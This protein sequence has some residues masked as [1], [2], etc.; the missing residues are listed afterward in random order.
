VNDKLKFVLISVAIMAAAVLLFGSETF[1]IAIFSRVLTVAIAAMGFNLLLG[2]TGQISI[3]HGAFMAIGAYTTAVLSTKLGLPFVVSII[4][5]ILFSALLGIVIGL[6]ALRLKGFYLAI[7]TLAFGVV[8]EQLIASIDFLGGHDGI[9][10]IPAFFGSDLA[11]F[12]VVGAVYVALALAMYRILESP[13]GLRYRMVRDSEVASRAYGVGLSRVKLS[14]FILSAVYGGIA[15]G[16][17]AH[18]VGFIVPPNF[19]LVL[20]LNILAIVIIGGLASVHGGLIGSIVIVGLPFLFSRGFGPYLSVI[21]GALLIIFVLFFPRGLAHGVFLGYTKYL[22][23]PFIALKNRILR[24][25][26]M[27]GSY[28]DVDG[29][30]LF[31]LERIPEPKSEHDSAERPEAAPILYIHGNTGCNLWF[32]HVM[33]IPGRRTI[34]LDLPNFGRSDRIDEADIDRYASSVAGFIRE[35]DLGSPVVIAH[36]LGGAVGIA[37]AVNHPELVSRLMLADSAAPDGLTTPEEH[38][39]IIELYRTSRSLMK[40]ALAAVTPTLDDNAFLNRLADNAMLMNPTA[41]TG[42]ARALERFDYT[43]RTQAYTGPVRVVVGRKDTIITEDMARRTADAFPSGE[44]LVLDDVG[45]SVMV[46]N[47]QEF[48][49]LV[50]EFVE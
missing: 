18:T 11:G 1:L 2:V 50:T 26:A 38:Y 48:V 14:A 30:S 40:K 23:V 8:V 4:P 35:L 25:N 39:G 37:L 29:T 13:V 43:D 28:V 46:E 27:G 22:Q 12:L 5:V 42:N 7:A 19:G 6:P 20:S 24:R 3:G 21:V 36:S 17:Y 33:D 44:L 9:R 49:R 10:S 31:Y 34:A 45:H 41:F 16:L 32:E 47:P 15:G